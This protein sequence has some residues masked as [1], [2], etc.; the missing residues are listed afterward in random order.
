MARCMRIWHPG[1]YYH[2]ISRGT[3]RLEIFQDDEDFITFLNL[4]K[5]IKKKYE[6]SIEAYCLMSNHYHLLI[7]AGEYPL[8]NAMAWIGGNYARYF[9]K[10]Y[11]YSGHVFENRYKS[12]L[13]DDEQ[14]LYQVSN[15]IHMN[16]VRAHI[17]DSPE[18]YKWSSYKN[19]Y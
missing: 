4:L 16:P 1:C 11:E 14:Y 8:S 10:K 15:Y 12:L 19:S 3:R 18:Q 7:K 6:F 13:I 17:V 2:I 9:N 5:G